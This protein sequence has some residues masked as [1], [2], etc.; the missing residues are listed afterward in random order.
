[1]GDFVVNHVH[2][3][4]PY[5]IDHPEW[6]N[7]GCI[8]GEENCDWTEHRLDCLFRDYMP[9]LN[10]KDRNASEQ[11]IEDILWWIETYDLDGGRI[12]AVKHVNDLAITNLAVRIN[13]RFETAGTDIYLKGETA[14]GWSG[15]NLESNSEQY[16]TI[17]HYMGPILLMVKQTL[18]SIMP[19]QILFLP[20]VKKII[21]I[22]IIGLREVKIS[23]LKVQSW[24]H[25]LGVTMFLVFHPF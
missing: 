2:Q 20:Q 5:H 16:G 17:N 12:D 15:H 1:M 11:M 18:S 13:E 3:D 19:P 14:M 22:L 10:W 9:D 25:L 23:I 4:H 24:F 21:C 7:Q 6:F 8:C